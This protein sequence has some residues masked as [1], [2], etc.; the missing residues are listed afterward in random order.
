MR[1]VLDNAAI[2]GRAR[3]WANQ[4]VLSLEPGKSWELL[5][6]GWFEF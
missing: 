4:F 5:L 3:R 6:E 2:L 1:S